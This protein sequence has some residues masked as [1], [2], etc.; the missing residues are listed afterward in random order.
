MVNFSPTST[1]AFCAF[2]IILI[3]FLYSLVPPDANA[4]AN[5]G[6]KTIASNYSIND[7]STNAS[8]WGS[9]DVLGSASRSVNQISEVVAH[10]NQITDN[11]GLPDALVYITLLVLGVLFCIGVLKLLHGFV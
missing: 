2:A 5:L 7:F 3:S 6:N 10:P 8:T 4:P 9:W 1:I 11:T